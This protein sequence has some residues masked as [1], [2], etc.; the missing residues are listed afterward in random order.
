MNSSG[1]RL[2]RSAALRIG[3]EIL[4]RLAGFVLLIA[5]ARTLGPTEL[6]EYAIAIAFAMILWSAAGLGI[7]RLA[8][9]EVARDAQVA[10]TLVWDMS[11]LKAL[12]ALSGTALFVAGIWLAG[13]SDRVALLV[14]LA[15][16]RV[17]VSLV[18]VSVFSVFQGLERMELYAR[19]I[20]PIRLGVIAAQLLALALGGRAV[21]VIAAELAAELVALPCAYLVLRRA[22]APLPVRLAPRGWPR[23]VRQTAPFGLQESLGV[24]VFRIDAILLGVL[25]TSAAVGVY[26]AGY[27]LLEAILFVVYALAA[28][29]LPLFATLQRGGSPSLEQAFA[30]S[31]RVGLM[32]TT[33]VAVALWLLAGPL[34]DALFGPAYADTVDVLPWLGFALVA[35]AV[36]HIAGTL[37]VVRLRG[38]VAVTL[39]AC[40]LAFNVALNIV[41]IPLYEAR[42]AAAATLV[43]EVAVAIAAVLL[44]RPLTGRLPL[45]GIVRGS[46]VAGALMAGVTALLA[47]HLLPA[48]IAGLATYGA[49][50]ALVERSALRGAGALLREAMSPSVARG[51]L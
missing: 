32:I 33:P 16:M 21:A 51:P 44:A 50:L 34:V 14:V 25:A 27:R 29:A 1:A 30:L 5:L 18:T 48:L 35:I 47:D 13:M 31:L 11:A 20:I 6:G 46:L 9:R 39:T 22:I 8:M 15:G 19:L 10:R 45:V 38:R 37:V 12:F 49:A 26:S 42:G 36:G 40:A 24:L 17:T 2:L 41:L 28:A 43:T 3:P 23:L 7:D 4:T